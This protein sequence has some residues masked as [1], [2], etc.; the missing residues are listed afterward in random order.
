MCACTSG[1]NDVRRPP[2]TARATTTNGVY[3]RVLRFAS[4]AALLPIAACACQEAGPV[5]PTVALRAF[6]EACAQV[7]TLTR[8]ALNAVG[9]GPARDRLSRLCDASVGLCQRNVASARRQRHLRHHGLG[10]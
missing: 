7:E 3:E 2:A 1:P 4:G 6:L 9:G 10:K 8:L 5:L